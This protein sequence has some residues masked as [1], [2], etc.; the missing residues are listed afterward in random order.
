MIYFATPESWWHL[1]FASIS[2]CLSRE[3]SNLVVNSSPWN[4][5]SGSSVDVEW[6]ENPVNTPP[7]SYFACPT[8]NHVLQ[9]YSNPFRINCQILSYSMQNW[10]AYTEA[11]CSPLYHY[12]VFILP[13]KGGGWY[14]QVFRV[15]FKISWNVGFTTTVS[16]AQL[17]LTT[18]FYFN[19]SSSAI[20]LNQKRQQDKHLP[21]CAELTSLL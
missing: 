8:L 12:A 21:P 15:R 10:C 9:R 16:Y 7:L 13:V 4:Y 20:L 18:A 14:T 17:G 2:Q 1:V 3:A 5:G 6:F 11:L 19:S